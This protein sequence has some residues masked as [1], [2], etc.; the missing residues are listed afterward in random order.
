[1]GSRLE[2]MREAKGPEIRLLDEVVGLRGMACQIERE[3]VERVEVGE[4]VTFEV[5]AGAHQPCS[6]SA[7]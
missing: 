6:H 1:M 3:I 5:G 7:G 2:A 4:G